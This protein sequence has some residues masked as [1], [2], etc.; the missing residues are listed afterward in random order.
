MCSQKGFIITSYKT[1]NTTELVNEEYTY[2]LQIKM[3]HTLLIYVTHKRLHTYQ[4][5]VC[6]FDHNTSTV[7]IND[8]IFSDVSRIC[9]TLSHIATHVKVDGVSTCSRHEEKNNIIY[10]MTAWEFMILW[11]WQNY[12]GSW[13]MLHKFSDLI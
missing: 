7:G 5:M 8:D 2:W 4:Q 1:W 12:K 10:S 13:L 9:V 6:S 3:T 11:S